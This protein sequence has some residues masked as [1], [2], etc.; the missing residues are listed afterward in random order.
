MHFTE[1]Y[2][3]PQYEIGVSPDSSIMYIGV[4]LSVGDPIGAK[5]IDM[6][7]FII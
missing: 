3:S 6:Y 2:H 7:R 4:F 5:C 1:V